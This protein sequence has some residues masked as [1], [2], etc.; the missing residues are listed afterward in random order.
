MP[1]GQVRCA[2]Y[3]RLQMQHRFRIVP[4]HVIGGTQ[5]PERK[6]QVEGIEPHVRLQYFNGPC[7]LACNYESPS[8]DKVIEIGIEHGRLLEFG[9]GCFVL[10]HPD[11]SKT[12]R[13]MSS[14]QIRSQSHGLAS[15]FVGV[16]ECDRPGTIVVPSMSPQGHIGSRKSGMSRWVIG[17]DG[18]R[19]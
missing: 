3:G 14:W 12:K 16:V 4:E 9:D 19:P 10:A 5:P 8:K 15:G 6:R 11:Q 13:D 18:Q 1:K 17:V 2:Q 7:R